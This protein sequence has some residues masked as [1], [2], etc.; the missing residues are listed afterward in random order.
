MKTA[1]QLVIISLIISFI[2]PGAIAED[3]IEAALTGTTGLMPAEMQFRFDARHTG[4][5]SAVAGSAIQDPMQKWNVTTGIGNT[6]STPA[7][8]NGVVYVG[9]YPSDVYAINASTGAVKWK[10]D[11]RGRVASSPAVVQGIVYIG[12]AYDWWEGQEIPNGKL[13]ALDAESGSVKWH[14]D[15]QSTSSIPGMVYSSPVVRDGIVYFSTGPGLRGSYASGWEETERGWFYALDAISGQ[16]RMYGELVSNE[17]TSPVVADGRVYLAGREDVTVPYGSYHREGL[18]AWSLSLLPNPIMWVWPAGNR[19]WV[20]GSSTGWTSYLWATPAVS[21]GVI[22]FNTQEL[23]A[24]NSTTGTTI[25][26]TKN[27]TSIRLSTRSSPAVADGV[28]YIGGYTGLYAINTVDGTLR[29]KFNTDGEVSC[30]PAIANGIVYIGRPGY[31]YAIDA[32]NGT[33]LWAYQLGSSQYDH[34]GDPVLVNGIIYV[35]NVQD[36]VR[37]LTAICETPRPPT[38]TSV[39]ITCNGIPVSIADPALLGQPISLNVTVDVPTGAAITNYVWTIDPPP[40]GAPAMVV[41]DPFTGASSFTPHEIAGVYNVYLFIEWV[42]P[43]GFPGSLVRSPD[44]LIP[45]IGPVSVGSVST[46]VDTLLADALTRTGTNST[47]F[48]SPNSYKAYNNKV[49][50]LARTI[51]SGNYA[52]AQGKIRNDLLQRTG[53]WVTNPDTRAMLIAEL[54]YVDLELEKL[55][56]GQ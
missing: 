4:D 21:D 44:S 56:P 47:A 55:V 27:D 29:W 42:T 12:V 35:N 18:Y 39:N 36:A 52:D 13:Y 41:G 33:A 40:E 28:V 20:P 49:N 8:A 16:V 25:W 7:V 11:T 14:F 15:G 53:Q 30:S 24:I 23:N 38:I 2:V 6:Y 26:S 34:V 10:F 5:Y 1:F 54:Q 46:E 31:L 48:D 50:A 3:S 51:E 32:A 22:Y 19:V 43:D 45:V 37:K 9:G 17:W